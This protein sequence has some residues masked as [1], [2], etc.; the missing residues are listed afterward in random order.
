MAR[1]ISIKNN[2][3]DPL[4][5]QDNTGDMVNVGPNSSGTL[6]ITGAP[7]E[8]VVQDNATYNV[9][10]TGIGSTTKSLTITSGFTLKTSN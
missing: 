2:S 4:L 8:I 1:S 7:S 5:V 10:S 9:Y 3:S 6:P